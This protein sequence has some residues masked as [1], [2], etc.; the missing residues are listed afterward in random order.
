MKGNC[1]GLIFEVQALNGVT[2]RGDISAKERN[3]SS[4]VGTIFPLDVQK[5]C[6][7]LELP[8]W[9]W[10]AMYESCI[11]LVC[12]YRPQPKTVNTSDF[13]KNV[14]HFF[15]CWIG[16]WTSNLT[17]H[18]RCVSLSKAYQPSSL[19]SYFLKSEKRWWITAFLNRKPAYMW[20]LHVLWYNG[21]LVK[22]CI[23]RFGL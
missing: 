19:P 21:I 11:P 8:V 4:D 3:S 12:C 1:S 15:S 16:S 10:S 22:Q 7:L 14:T 23:C 17:L 20:P 18:K 5:F 6:Y 9:Y 13:L 2:P